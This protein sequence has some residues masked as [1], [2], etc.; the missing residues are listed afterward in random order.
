M[1]ESGRDWSETGSKRDGCKPRG[2]GVCDSTNPRARPT[3]QDVSR[4]RAGGMIDS[5]TC[6]IWHM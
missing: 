3:L 4:L 1:Y 2:R 6:I 5:E